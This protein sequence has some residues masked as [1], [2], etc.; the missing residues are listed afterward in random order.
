MKGTLSFIAGDNLGSH[1]IG[2]FVENFSSTS[3]WCRWCC[4][5]R[6][7]FDEDPITVCCFP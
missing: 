1:C 2:G 7:E 4:I 3:C 6:E 5:T